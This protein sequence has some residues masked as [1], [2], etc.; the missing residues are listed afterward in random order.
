MPFPTP[1]G[2][3]PN[4]GSPA[5]PTH[6]PN[7]PAPPRTAHAI[8]REWRQVHLKT[9][10]DVSMLDER[11]EEG[12]ARIAD[13]AETVKSTLESELDDASIT[14]GDDVGDVLGLALCVLQ[15]NK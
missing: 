6:E 11:D 10:Y 3:V 13:A 1:G 7:E 2:A 15:E 4:R 5:M 14:T 12:T 9:A 8:C